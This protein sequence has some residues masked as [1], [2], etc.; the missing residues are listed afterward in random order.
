LHTTTTAALYELLL[1]FGCC[2]FEIIIIMRRV[3]IVPPRG[4]TPSLFCFGEL[5]KCSTLNFFAEIKKTR[6]FFFESRSAAE[7]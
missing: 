3:F 1:L 2:L 4:V 7:K 5:K 6:F